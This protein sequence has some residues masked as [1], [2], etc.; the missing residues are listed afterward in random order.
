MKK[1]IF[2]LFFLIVFINLQAQQTEHK[3]SW[4]ISAEA[5]LPTG[6]FNT[7]Y[8]FIGGASVGARYVL[9]E[10]SMVTASAGYLN[11]F[12]KGGGTGVSFIPIVAGFKYHFVPDVFVS[13]EG[14]GAIPTYSKGGILACVIPGVGYQISHDFSVELNYTGLAQYGLLV[15]SVN[16]GVS[17]VF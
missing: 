9:S 2:S 5:G 16:M 8:S 4:E 12:R 15:G 10:K 6:L 17:Y 1:I 13:L 11:F 7:V 14:G 3:L